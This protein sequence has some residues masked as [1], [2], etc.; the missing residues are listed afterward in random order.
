MD[1]MRL[2]TFFPLNYFSAVFS[3]TVAIGYVSSNGKGN[4]WRNMF[5]LS[6]CLNL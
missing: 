2:V 3:E 6:C 1:N 4:A 5:L